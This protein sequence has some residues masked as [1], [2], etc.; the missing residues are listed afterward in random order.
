M[1]VLFVCIPREGHLAPLVPIALALREA[2]HEVAFA[3][4]ARFNPQVEQA[5]FQAF[6]AGVEATEWAD[7][8]GKVW[9]S[10]VPGSTND[11]IMT[12]FG[13]YVFG[14]TVAMRFIEDL[15]NVLEAWPA[16]LIVHEDTALGRRWRPS[17]LVYRMRAS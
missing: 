16:D 5:G 7:E 4:G 14:G 8:L 2:G 12:A 3:T 11:E 6:A 17:T 10:M 1:R 13:E 9:E 15:P